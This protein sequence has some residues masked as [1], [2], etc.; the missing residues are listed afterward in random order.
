MK[1]FTHAP[2]MPDK[3][4]KDFNDWIKQINEALDKIK[5]TD[6]AKRLKR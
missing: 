5:G 3:R 1:T 6:V 4:P 2:V